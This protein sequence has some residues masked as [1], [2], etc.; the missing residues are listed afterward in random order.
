M[1]N[2]MKTARKIRE[3][4]IAQNMTQMNLADAM[5]VS[6]QAV[7][8]W[9]RGNS[10]PDIS[11]LEQLCAVL[12]INLDE[13]LGSSETTQTLSKIINAESH[14]TSA[15]QNTAPVQAPGGTYD[16]E[17]PAETNIITDTISSAGNNTRSEEHTSELQSH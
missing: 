8:N 16:T 12:H 2:T 7:S 11:K 9:E 5:E 10:M 6:Y 14:D 17:A 15:A 1:F 3:A 13:L 4:R